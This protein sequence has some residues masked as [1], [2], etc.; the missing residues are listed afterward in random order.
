MTVATKSPRYVTIVHH[1]QE[2]SVHG[3]ADLGYWQRY[4]AR[5]GLQPFDA[6]GWAELVLLSGTDGLWGAA[7]A[8]QHETVLEPRRPET[9]S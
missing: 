2:V 7:E 5:E 8:W 1:V 6:Q 4:L 9:S 3:R